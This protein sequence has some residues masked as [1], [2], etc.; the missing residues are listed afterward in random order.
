MGTY[1]VVSAKLPYKNSV[2][3]NTPGRSTKLYLEAEDQIM[4]WV[5]FFVGFVSAATGFF[6]SSHVCSIASHSF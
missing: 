4:A 3:K 5:F 6:S 1:L 2:Q